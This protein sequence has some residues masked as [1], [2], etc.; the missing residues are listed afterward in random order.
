[1]DLLAA[2]R[3]Q[4][5]ARGMGLVQASADTARPGPATALKPGESPLEFRV[6]D[7]GIVRKFLLPEGVD[8][9]N[10]LLIDV[11]R[12]IPVPSGVR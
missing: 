11:E 12:P 1:M 4:G 9:Q 10:I 8:P 2:H 7:E 3:E 5:V 6:A